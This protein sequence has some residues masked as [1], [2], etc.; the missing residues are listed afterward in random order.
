M[1][2]DRIKYLPY[3]IPTNKLSFT[4]FPLNYVKES[5]TIAP[6]I[7]TEV[8]CG[9]TLSHQHSGITLELHSAKQCTMTKQSTATGRYSTSTLKIL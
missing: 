2:K 3:A 8:H 9:T 5:K 1:I 4:T 7:A 6:S